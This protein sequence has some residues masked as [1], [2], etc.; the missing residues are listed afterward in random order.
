MWLFCINCRNSNAK[1]DTETTIQTVREK[2]KKDRGKARLLPLRT[3]EIL[4][5]QTNNLKTCNCNIALQLAHTHTH[6][7]EERHSSVKILLTKENRGRPDFY[8][9]KKAQ[10]NSRAKERDILPEPKQQPVKN[11]ERKRR[12]NNVP[13]IR[14]C[15]AHTQAAPGVHDQKREQEEEQ[16][17]AAQGRHCSSELELELLYPP[18]AV[19][20]APKKWW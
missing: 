9:Q 5:T 17:G 12:A 15:T 3:L 2:A 16:D 6:K 8:L 1:K 19:C 20:W 7:K 4:K 14:R 18:S 13:R 11:W 10:I